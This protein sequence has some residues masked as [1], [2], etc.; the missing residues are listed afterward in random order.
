MATAKFNS[1]TRVFQFTVN[2]KKLDLMVVTLPKIRL[3]NVDWTVKM[4]K[5]LIV[6]DEDNDDN[7]KSVLSI[8][9]ASDFGG[10]I[11]GGDVPEFNWTCKVS[12]NFEL[13]HKNHEAD[14]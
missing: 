9:L 8:Y 6:D 2:V 4:C 12:A 3:S 10:R 11:A 14:R 1:S 5:K 7:S 13:F